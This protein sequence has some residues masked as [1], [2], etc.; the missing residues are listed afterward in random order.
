VFYK[1]TWKFS[2][3]LSFYDGNFDVHLHV[4]KACFVRV[5][6]CHLL[7]GINLKWV[8]PLAYTRAFD[9]ARTKCLASNLKL[10]L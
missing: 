5:W 10:K 1:S 2:S 9:Y 4:L 3:K 6:H 8:A 7:P